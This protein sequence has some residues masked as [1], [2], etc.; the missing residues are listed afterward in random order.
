V[1]PSKPE[2]RPAVRDFAFAATE[3]A[4]WSKRG[5]L[6][7]YRLADVARRYL[8]AT[9]REVQDRDALVGTH[10]LS[11]M[12]AS[13]KQ[14]AALLQLGILGV[15]AASSAVMLVSTGYEVDAVAHVRRLLESSL[16]GRAVM[17]DTSGEYA[18]RW[19]TGRSPGTLKKLISQF[20]DPGDVDV[21]DV[22][23]HADVR[24]V[25]LLAGSTGDGTTDRVNVGPERKP[26]RAAAVQF[27]VAYECVALVSGL[28]AAFEVAVEI[29]RY[30]SD[31]FA[32]EGE[33]I[34]TS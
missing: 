19:L 29:P 24:G 8:A 28:A 9:V 6:P 10:K 27:A 3:D 32:K 34:G 20:G 21:L 23:T 30:I 15:Q 14:R 7:H 1:A 4:L 11:T 25:A 16:R 17:A 22:T 18:R 31:E 13:T 33:R 5:Q 2:L 26:T 12:S